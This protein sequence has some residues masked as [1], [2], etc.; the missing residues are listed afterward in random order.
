MTQ[1]ELVFDC[2][3]PRTNPYT[4]GTHNHRL[5]EYWRDGGG[6]I[7]T[8]EIHR[9]GCET[10]RIRSD[11]RPYLKSKGL[12]YKCLYLEPGNREY[13]VIERG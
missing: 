3:L 2:P 7:T 11:I 8:K 9:L 6:R 12:N 10:A 4:P 5:Y 13:R 1:T